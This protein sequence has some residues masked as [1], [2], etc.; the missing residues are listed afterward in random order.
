MRKPYSMISRQALWIFQA[1]GYAL[2]HPDRSQPLAGEVG[3]SPPSAWRDRRADVGLVILVAARRPTV[4]YPGCESPLTCGT[5]VSA[6]DPTMI[7][8]RLGEDAI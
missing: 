6:S 1:V 5:A 2:V 3:L 7:A 8:G 4:R